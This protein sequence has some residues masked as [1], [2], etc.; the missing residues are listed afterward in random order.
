MFLLAACGQPQKLDSIK[1]KEK[2]P[3]KT[4]PVQAKPEK[5]IQGP[6]NPENQKIL[7]DQTKAFGLEG[8]KATH[9]YAVH[10]NNDKYIDLALLPD[11]YSIPEFYIF[12]KKKNKFLKMDHNPFQ[13]V[14]K[15]SFLEFSDFNKDGVIDVLVMT[16]NQRSA[17]K[18]TPP[19]LFM[20]KLDKNNKL[21]LKQHPFKFPLDSYSSVSVFDYNQDG[22]LD[23]YFGNWIDVRKR[24][25]ELRPNRFFQGIEFKESGYYGFQFN[26]ISDLFKGEWE[27]NKGS[28]KYIN[29][30]PTFG[31][32]LC[33]LNFDGRPEIFNA[34]TSGHANRVWNLS[35]VEGKDIFTDVS[36]NSHLA[37]DK[38]GS[39]LPLGGGHTF[40][41]NCHDYNKSGFFDVAVG[42]LFHSYDLDYKD[43]SS[44]LTGSNNTF[45]YQ[46]IRT[47]YH[48]DDGTESWDQGD[49]R[50]I[51]VDI[52]ADGK[53]DLLID[54]SGFPPKSRLVSFVQADDYS[55]ADVSLKWGLDVLNPSGT[56]V[57]D[58]DR[59]GIPEL[60]TG[61]T[62]IRES[63]IQPRVY[64]FKNHS[65]AIGQKL[66]ISFDS[67]SRGKS[68][69]V[70]NNK[71]QKQRFIL[72]STNGPQSSQ[73]ESKVFIY[74]GKGIKFKSL[75]VP[76]FSKGLKKLSLE[77]Y[78]QSKTINLSFCRGQISFKKC[79]NL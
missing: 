38:I 40:Y 35:R 43:R 67:Y 34:N 21:V 25:P 30:R 74:S 28:N 36:G 69:E 20:G 24:P 73:S 49:R 32:G 62:N 60:L 53:S 61:Q 72:E 15:A 79:R 52:N 42:E 78:K 27:F 71:G 7:I 47:E 58:V 65:K 31:T 10:L 64:F 77:K 56:I 70:L 75:H 33:D 5:F 16:L 46:F 2:T 8:V 13:K 39:H 23:V 55:Y 51:W 1:L 3:K 66:V 63:R 48:K 18:I 19:T 68:F 26:E 11:F 57:L 6:S 12:N 59:D 9:L 76:V 37:S 41:L 50:S 44:I 14:V 29:A 17:L 4:T 45:P 22:L 54:N